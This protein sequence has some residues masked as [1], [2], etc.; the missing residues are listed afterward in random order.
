MVRAILKM[1]PGPDCWDNLMLVIQCEEEKVCQIVRLKDRHTALEL[2]RQTA[3]AYYDH[4]CGK[5]VLK[6]DGLDY[7]M[8][9]R[10]WMAVHSCMDQWFED[11]VMAVEGV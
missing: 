3:I 1:A 4:H 9:C 11:Y 10:A 2:Y 7:P 6:I 8:P 5:L